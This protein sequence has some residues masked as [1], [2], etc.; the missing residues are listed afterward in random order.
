MRHY[1]IVILVHP[2]QSEQVGAMVDRYRALIEKS[3]GIMHRLEDWGRR[4]L[5]YPINKIHKA[6]NVLMNVECDQSALDELKRLFRF[7]DA[8]I[9]SMVIRRDEAVTDTSPIMLEKEREQS[10]AE[11]SA[12]ASSSPAPVDRKPEG[13][14]KPASAEKIEAKEQPAPDEKPAAKKKPVVEEKPAVEEKPVVEEKPATREKS[15]RKDKPAVR[16]EPA[17]EEKPA[18]SEKS[19]AK[20]KPAVKKKPAA[21]DTTT[22]NPTAEETKA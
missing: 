17:V 4:Q 19:V 14:V 3:A 22:K 2:D 6:H 12:P 18:A 10:Q 9:R 13:E 7:N 5:A 16:K 8:V 20:A 1:E 11:S 15:A 21:E